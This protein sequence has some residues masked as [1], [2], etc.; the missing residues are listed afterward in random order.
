MWCVGTSARRWLLLLALL[1]AGAVPL[2]AQAP[3]D[4]TPEVL[5]SNGLNAF[6]SGDYATAVTAFQRLIQLFGNEPSLQREMEGVFYALGCSLYNQNNYATAITTFADYAKRFPKAKFLDEAVFR[7]GTAHQF[8]EAYDE[9]IAAYRQL[10]AQFPNSAFAEDAAYQIAICRIVQERSGD[11]IAALEAFLQSFPN[12]EFFAQAK[13]YLARAYFQANKMTEALDT[14]A[15]VQDITR[16]LDHLVYANFLAIEIGDAAFDNTDYDMALRAY[17]RVRTKGALLKLQT[18]LA[19]RAQGQLA[20]LLRQPIDP[21]QVQARFRQERRLRSALGGIK[22]TLTKLQGMPEYDSGLF[23]RIGRCFYAVDRFWESRV[24]FARVVAEA[25]DPVIKEAGHYD[26]ILSLNRLRRFPDLIAEADRYLAAFGQDEKLIKSER[27]PSVGFMKGEAY[28]NQEEFEQAEKEMDGLLEKYPAHAQ[29]TRIEFYRALSIAMQERYEESIDLFQK[30]LAAHPND[31]ALVPEV[32]YWLP[33]AMYYNGQYQE[34][35]PLFIDYAARYPMSVYAPE[36]SYRAALCKYAQEQFEEAAADL[37]VW[38]EQHPEHVFRWEAL[39]TRGDACAA[40]GLLE[41]ARQAYRGVTAEA[42]AYH[43]FALK[44]LVKVYQALDT[45]K[46]YREMAT[47]FSDFVRDNPDSPN[48][49]EAA[50]EAGRAL[51]QLKRTDDARRLYWGML[52]RHGDNRAW[53][54]FGPILD[55]LRALYADQPTD[56]L[57]KDAQAAEGKARAVGRY[58]LVSRLVFAQMRWDRREPAPAAAELARRFPVEQ[59]DAETLAFVGEHLAKSGSTTQGLA[60]LER[61]L[62]DFPN[63]P[64]APVAYARRAEASMAG[65]NASNALADATLAI[66]QTY[67]PVLLMEA[68]FTRAQ[69]RQALGQYED[70]ITDY[71]AVV[72][73]RITPRPLKPR[74]LL[75]IATCYEGLGDYR[76]AIPFYQRI[77]VMYRAYTQDVAQAYLRSGVAFEQIKDREA[78]GKT[79]REMLELASLAGR[80]ELEE[81]RVRLAKLGP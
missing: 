13:V 51:R 63:S 30:W 18:Q 26:L 24:A 39:V 22:D 79:Y 34:C 72:A 11:A 9:A 65:G 36:A 54:G 8:L 20:A 12:S 32:Q 71:N 25:Q 77:Y 19:E 62:K 21:A 41:E 57:R 7:T 81:A 60:Y 6:N 40:A 74:A 33:V 67:E 56:A 5:Y 1:A 14:L 68:T 78:A 70:A 42:G 15:S 76:K 3:A 43:F 44:Q 27:V 58:T 2:S 75:G 59:L 45:E 35:L 69:A 52:E 53:Q 55:D 10:I 49:V 37:A 80:P 50:Y 38:S 64:M 4:D 28:V 16:S 17:R 66:D 29:K 31:D 46:D 47:V 23:H 61:L 48:A 73:N